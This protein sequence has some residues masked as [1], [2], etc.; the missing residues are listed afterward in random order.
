M[1]QASRITGVRS[2]M[3][4]MARMKPALPAGSTM[5]G[6]INTA[7]LRLAHFSS[8]LAPLAASPPLAVAGSAITRAS[9]TAIASAGAIGLWQATVSF[10]APAR[11]AA[12][13]AS[14]AAPGIS[15]LPATIS[16]WPRSSLSALLSATGS[17][18]ARRT[19][20]V[21]GRAGR[22]IQGLAPA[23]RSGAD[24][25]GVPSC[26]SGARKLTSSSRNPSPASLLPAR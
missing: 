24:V 6:P 3:R 4:S 2:S 10:P 23:G 7:A 25:T 26:S 12:V 21:S 1:A 15:V 5:P 11:R 17:G 19:A 20:W 9:G 8:R 18:H 14:T 13:A 22:G 16:T